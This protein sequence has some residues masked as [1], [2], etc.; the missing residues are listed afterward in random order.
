MRVLSRV[1]STCSSCLLSPFFLPTRAHVVDRLAPHPHKKRARADLVEGGAVRPTLFPFSLCVPS[2][3]DRP[4]LSH[5]LPKTGG[6]FFRKQTIT[7]CISHGLYAPEQ[8]FARSLQTSADSTQL[9]QSIPEDG[10]TPFSVRLHEDSFRAHNT[11]SPSL[12]IEVTKDSLLKM[13][14]EM[15][16]MRRMEQSADALYKSKLI[17]GFCHL[18]IGQVRSTAVSPRLVTSDVSLSTHV[19]F[20]RKPSQLVLSLP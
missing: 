12:D 11:E 6:A 2:P 20:S 5:S 3:F 10:S 17:R 18:A 1:G 7:I 16:T 8:P 13:Y 4:P 15:V 9:T 14:N 19:L